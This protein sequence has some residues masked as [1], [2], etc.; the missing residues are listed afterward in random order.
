MMLTWF[1]SFVIPPTGRKKWTSVHLFNP[2][3][4]TSLC[5]AGRSLDDC[6]IS[7][8]PAVNHAHAG[9]CLNIDD[10][11]TG[12]NHPLPLSKSV[13]D[14]TLSQVLDCALSEE[15][16]CVIYLKRLGKLPGPTTSANHLGKPP[17]KI[18]CENYLNKYPMK[19][20]L[21]ML[22]GAYL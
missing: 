16:V 17:E 7:V 10:D 3:R 12:L 6:T 18:T 19:C 21:T 14:T 1:P 13:M 22:P 4:N 8:A 11:G 5:K 20:Y 2:W 9:S 15:F